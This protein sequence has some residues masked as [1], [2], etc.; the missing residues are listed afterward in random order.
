MALR[1]GM[2]DPFKGLM[3]QQT[4]SYV[5]S[6]E[7]EAEKAR[8]GIA[9]REPKRQ[10]AEEQFL[11]EHEIM[12]RFLAARK[13]KIGED[14]AESYGNLLQDPQF[15]ET[16][17]G[18]FTP[19]KTSGQDLIALF[20]GLSALTFLSGGKGRYSG[21]AGMNNLANAMEGWN[22]GRQD[23]FKTEMQEFDK[24]IKATQEHN[25]GIQK[26]LEQAISM[27]ST[28]RDA[29]L[30]QLKALEAE[31]GDSELA[32]NLRA[33]RFDRADKIARDSITAADKVVAKWQDT[34]RNRENKSADVEAR[35]QLEMMRQEFANL[36]AETKT[37]QSA[38]ATQQQFIAQRAVTALAGA[39]SAAESI[40]KLPEMSS[41]GILPFLSNKPG[42]MNYLQTTAAREITGSEAK[43]LEVLFT[44]VSRYLA[45][46]EA[47]GTATGLVSLSG[48]LDKLKPMPG[49]K[50]Q[51]IALKMADIR[52]IST[53]S[54]KA[55]INSGL[56]PSQQAN[57][58]QELVDRMEKAIPY[59]T[60]DVV[61]AI[62]AGRRTLGTGTTGVG[63]RGAGPQE[64]QEAMSKSGKPIVFRNGQ[65]EYK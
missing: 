27:L 32:Y 39:A 30:G 59:T 29:A 46:I 1:L 4:P 51:D 45:T 21:N 48:Q 36:R 24:N 31:L 2:T 61:N 53:E 3:A 44:G 43:A 54:I 63:S 62:T 40:M 49:D 20:A 9:E 65:W 12:G 16:E 7:Q 23:L 64:G 14:Y 28:N 22:K 41:V 34:L 18:Q 6:A 26:R 10:E 35:A 57:A 38:R 5:T 17:I 25:K 33:G 8:T 56:M 37:G 42:L 19:S 55:M 52:R 13:A 60:D 58:A 15:R 11:G 50:V 47:S